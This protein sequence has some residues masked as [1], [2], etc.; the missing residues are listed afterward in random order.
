MKSPE[1]VELI[2]KIYRNLIDGKPIIQDDNYNLKKLFNREFTTGHLFNN[3]NDNLMNIKTPN[4]LGV[5]I[6]IVIEAKKQIKIKLSDELNQNDGIRFKESNKGMI[7]NKL[8]NQNGLLINSSKK[9]SIIY[10]DNKVGLKTND[11]VLKTIDYNL[12]ENLKKYSEKKMPI[13]ITINAFIDQAL[14]ITVNDGINSLTET[15]CKIQKSITSPITKEKIITQISKLGNTPFIANKI[16]VNMDDNIFISIKELNELR[17]TLIDKLISI[18]TTINR[19]IDNLNFIQE[20]VTHSSECKI[21][22]FVNNEEQLKCLINQVNRI[23]TDDF[24]LYNKYKSPS[25][26]YR[27]N[28]VSTELENLKDENLLLT[29]LG[30]INMYSENNN[31]IG[32]YFL[33]VVNSF[34]C[35]FLKEKGIKTITLSPE[36]N[37]KQI[38][39]LSE[40]ASNLEVIVYGTLELMIMNHCI[41]SMNDDCTSCKGNKYYL[42]NKKN[43]LFPIINKNCKTHIMHHEKINLLNNIS[44]LKQIGINNFRL[45]LFDETS[46][47]IIKILNNIKKVVEK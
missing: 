21:S 15:G 24:N 47:E 42:K 17:R 10:L 41:I 11:T 31:C 8:Y 28:R 14:S 32:D 27:T 20:K 25:V 44:Y 29:E 38:K 26:F 18:K 19:K 5:P 33:N 16:T 43:E 7:I 3:K 39:D 9:N 30:A 22:V 36:L 34:H 40:F 13:N 1:Y 45:E 12:N 4:H 46:E 6:G 2:T 23:Y 37:L 35:N